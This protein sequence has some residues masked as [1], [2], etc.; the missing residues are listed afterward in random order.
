MHHRVFALGLVCLA[1]LASL[2]AA[3]QG[4]RPSGIGA[5]STPR[6]QG[7]PAAAAAAPARTPTRAAVDPLA[8]RQA[9]Y[10]VAVV[11]SEPVTNHEVQVRL[12]RISEQLARQGGALPPHDVLVREVLE[13]TILEKAQLQAAREI[14]IKVD[15]LAVSQAEQAVARQNNVSVEEMHRRVAA[16]GISPERFREELHS[17]LVLQRLREREV[18]ARV[19]VTDL[20]IDQYL[21]EQKP[22]AAQAAGSIDLAHVL[23]PVP[24]NA[25]AAEVAQ[26]QTR[27]QSVADKARAG[28]DFA[29]L[30]RTYSAAPEAAAGGGMGMRSNDRYPELFVQAT[31]ALPFWP[32]RQTLPN[33]RASTPRTAAPNRGAIWAGPRQAA[34]CPSSSRP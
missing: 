15:D 31:Q 27:A 16:D 24:E 5:A 9:D 30:A 7:A 32:A 2:P 20:D 8:V 23:I 11:N 17:Q 6:M 22:A 29:A 26:L 19:R 21:R 28:E 18:D 34:M 10:I 1:S 14:G 13:R 33:W 12:E 4:L 25:S 3:A